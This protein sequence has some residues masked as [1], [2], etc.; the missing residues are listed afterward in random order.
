M[1]TIEQIKL[2]DVKFDQQVGAISQ[3]GVTEKIVASELGDFTM[4]YIYSKVGKIKSRTYVLR[5]GK[6]SVTDELEWD[7]M[8]QELKTKNYVWKKD[9]DGKLFLEHNKRGIIKQILSS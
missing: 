9:D 1:E 6:T 2:K 5:R 4:F 8:I 7:Q 3:G